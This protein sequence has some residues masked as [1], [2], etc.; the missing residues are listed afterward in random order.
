MKSYVSEFGN[1]L[2]IVRCNCDVDTCQ[3]WID[4]HYGTVDE[5]ALWP[6]H[7]HSWLLGRSEKASIKVLWQGRY[8]PLWLMAKFALLCYAIFKGRVIQA[9]WG[10]DNAK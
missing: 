4:F 9:W 5:S 8:I 10:G 3:Q 7:F 1:E 2:F 6:I